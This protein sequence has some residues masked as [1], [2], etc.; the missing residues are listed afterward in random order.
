[1]A[2]V[3]LF[4]PTYY[5][6]LGVRLYNFEGKAV[7]PEGTAVIN[8]EQ[9]VSRE[10]TPYKQIVG[11][12]NFAT[13]KEAQ[14]YVASQKLPRYRIVGNNPFVSPVPLE[15]V[16]QFKLVHSEGSVTLGAPNTGTPEIKIFE[17]KGARTK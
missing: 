11:V 7:T 12:E 3:F 1:M 4:Y 2:P 15:A 5:R 14:D 6:S 16:E 9:K 17:Y 8:F 10:G 13:F